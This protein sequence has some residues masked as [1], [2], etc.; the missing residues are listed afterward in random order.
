METETKDILKGVFSHSDNNSKD[1][2]DI[3]NTYINCNNKNS[4]WL[5]DQEFVSTINELSSSIKNFMKGSK[6]N[7]KTLSSSTDTLSSQIS[8]M[9]NSLNE[10]NIQINN[11]LNANKTTS[12]KA[13]VT[14]YKD[15]LAFTIE[16]LNK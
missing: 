1:V 9:R 15:K 3:V 5:N 16:T 13:N 8:Q 10:M 14:S 12:G 6:A 11:I 2:I 7:A 4:K